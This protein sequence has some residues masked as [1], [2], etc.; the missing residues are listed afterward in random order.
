MSGNENHVDLLIVDETPLTESSSSSESVQEVDPAPEDPVVPEE[1]KLK[2]TVSHEVEVETP[3]KETPVFVGIVSGTVS[4]DPE[5]E[6][7]NDVSNPP[8]ASK[9]KCCLII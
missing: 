2:D 7:E 3:A 6:P 5:P 1:E 8:N 4:V 9:S